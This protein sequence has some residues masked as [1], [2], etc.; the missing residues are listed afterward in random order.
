MLGYISKCYINI[1][2][3]E[4]IV[5]PSQLIRRSGVFIV[6]FKHVSLVFLL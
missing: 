1:K 4:I 6:D 5:Q 2:L 3:P